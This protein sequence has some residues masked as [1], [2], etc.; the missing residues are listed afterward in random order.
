MNFKELFPLQVVI[1]LD[2]RPDRYKICVEEEFPQLKIS[3]IRKS[4]FVPDNI[5]HPWWRGDVGCMVSHYQ[6]LQ[7]A[8]NL[9]TNVFIFEDDIHFK[10]NNTLELLDLACNELS[11][12]QWDMVYLAGNILKPF[13]KVTQHLARLSQCQS[14][15]GYGVSKYFLERLLSYINLSHITK[16]IDL[17]YADDVIPNHECLITIPMLGIQRDSYSDIEGR[18]VKYSDYL[19]KRYEENYR[20]N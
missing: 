14:T 13:H 17:I 20:E 12:M 9:N 2:S 10:E 19:E 3:P 8:L 16:P 7:A 5:D 15:C 18:E 1:N 4:G 11:Y 6:V